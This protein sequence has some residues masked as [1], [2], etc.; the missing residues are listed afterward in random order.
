MSFEKCSEGNKNQSL[1][2]LLKKKNLCLLL[3]NAYNDITI[4]HNVLYGNESDIQNQKK[5]NAKK[6][7]LNGGEECVAKSFVNVFI[8]AKI[9]MCKRKRFIWNC[10]IRTFI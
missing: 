1:T 10:L 4:Y 8:L 2:I 3:C 7:F 5:K 9:K 6:Y